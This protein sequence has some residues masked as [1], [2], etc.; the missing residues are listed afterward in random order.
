MPESDYKV[1]VDR[2]KFMSDSAKSR[3]REAKSGDDR[4]SVIKG[5]LASVAASGVF[6]PSVRAARAMASSGGAHCSV[7]L[8]NGSG[9]VG[10]TVTLNCVIE[11]EGYRTADFSWVALQSGG[12]ANVE[13]LD[14]EGTCLDVTP[15]QPC[16]GPVRVR[17][18]PSTFDLALIKV[19]VFE[20][21]PVLCSA[22]GSVRV[23]PDK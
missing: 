20:D 2:R 18:L 22:V 11:N 1:D 17:I 13:I 8:G 4:R 9:H 5:A 7:K 19:N 16:V 23:L 15:A 6:A 3:V 12:S 14:T 21:G 10:D